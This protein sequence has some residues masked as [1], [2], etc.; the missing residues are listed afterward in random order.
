MYEDI[1]YEKTYLKQVIARID[2]ISALVGVDKSLPSKLASDLARDFP[3]AEPADSI[4]RH[5]QLTPS[6]VQQTETRFKQWNFYGKERE[7][8][9]AIAPS[10][11]F[12]SYQRYTTFEDMQAQFTN[13]TT[14]L[15][16]QFPDA[17][18]GRFGLRY[19]NVIEDIPLPEPTRWEGYI[20]PKLLESRTFFDE[21]QPLTRLMQ[22]A[23]LKFGDI[24]VNFQFGMPNPDHPAIIRRP[25][26][27][28]DVDAYVQ[29]AHAPAESLR[30][31]EQAHAHIQKLFE[32]S[33]TGK[34]RELMH[35]RQHANL[36]A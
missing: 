22:A 2:F 23:E 34:L 27:V 32:N 11:A 17:T 36:Q 8:H 35:A 10:F 15:L 29:S 18:V 1:C 3:I 12:I 21:A 7:K 6:G 31:M 19:I 16:K 14:A 13:F 5:V 9:L 24:D 30:L 25:Q 26:F 20:A 28:L 33:I 4:A